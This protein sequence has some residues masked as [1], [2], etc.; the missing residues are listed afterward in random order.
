MPPVID[1]PTPR[2]AGIVWHSRPATRLG[3]IFVDRIRPKL[4]ISPRPS[5]R[6]RLG[7]EAMATDHD[8][9]RALAARTGRPPTT[10]AVSGWRVISVLRWSLW[11]VSW[12]KGRA[13]S[14]WRS[15]VRH[16]EPARLT[17]QSGKPPQRDQGIAIM[18][19]EISIQGAY[20]R[21]AGRIKR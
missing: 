1:V 6:L 15:G 13:H 19:P 14:E 18:P 11:I 9:A 5:A 20:L 16:V 12:S 4:A 8:G 3:W 17:V 10:R 21:E 2:P 7:V